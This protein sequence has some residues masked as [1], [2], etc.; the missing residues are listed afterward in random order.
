MIWFGIKPP[1][2]RTDSAGLSPRVG[3]EKTPLKGAQACQP[4]SEHLLLCHS[5]DGP[6]ASILCLVLL[7]S[8]SESHETASS[9]NL[10]LQCLSRGWSIPEMR[11]KGINQHSHIPALSV[12][13]ALQGFR[14]REQGLTHPEVTDEVK[15][16]LCGDP[17][18]P[19]SSKCTNEISWGSS[20]THW[21]K[22][23]DSAT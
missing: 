22:N 21:V 17:W 6:S 5:P 16:Y 23:L 9:I 20:I 1:E 2:E 19:L 14:V 11:Q 10:P 15:Y 7:G 13:A 8:K 12:A 4:G 18:R 3:S